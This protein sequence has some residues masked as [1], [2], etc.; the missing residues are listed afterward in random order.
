MVLSDL[1]GSWTGSL[2][3]AATDGSIGHDILQTTVANWRCGESF[4]AFCMVFRPIWVYAGAFWESWE[5]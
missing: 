2:T 5:S 3:S 4:A 1:S